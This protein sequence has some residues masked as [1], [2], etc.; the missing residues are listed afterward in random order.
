MGPWL[1]R[2]ISRDP[3]PPNPFQA[4]E[5]PPLKPLQVW[6][7]E[8]AADCEFCEKMH[9]TKNNREDAGGQGT[10]RAVSSRELSKAVAAAS[11][12]G[13]WQTKAPRGQRAFRRTRGSTHT[14]RRTR[15][16]AHTARRTRGSTHSQTHTR[17]H[18]H[19]QTHHPAHTAAFGFQQRLPQSVPVRWGRPV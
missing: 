9:E 7:G 19:S 4:S 16:S 18:T 2:L 8:L 17:E 1:G 14:A 11:G 15:G 13:A 12:V 10:G 5:P 3:L 6:G